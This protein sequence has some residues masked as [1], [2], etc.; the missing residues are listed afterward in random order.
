LDNRK[1]NLRICTILENSHNKNVSTNNKSGFTGVFFDKESKKWKAYIM[2][3]GV[4]YHLGFFL[5]KEKAI[6]AR[7][8]A[9]LKYNFL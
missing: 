6:Q 3:N 8:N 9:E 5:D 4:N 2:C 7:K 1:S